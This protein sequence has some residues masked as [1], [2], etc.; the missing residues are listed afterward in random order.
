[1]NPLSRSAL[2]ERAEH[3]LSSVVVAIEFTLISVMIG[4]ILF[5]LMDHATP[6]L[7]DLKFEQMPYIVGGLVIILYLWTEVIAHSLSFIGW[8]IDLIHNLLYIVFAFVL[9][10][11]MHFLSDPL[12]WYGMS[13]VWALVSAVVVVYDLRLI[14]SRRGA[15]KGAKAALYQTALERQAGLVRSMPLAIGLSIVLLGLVAFFPELFLVRKGHIVL[16]IIQ[17]SAF[18]LFLRRTIRAFNRE[19]SQIAEKIVEDI[20]LEQ[21]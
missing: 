12:G 7:R 13:V 20:E 16:A 19:R 15:A 14:K 11:Q 4:V 21:E 6:I 5:P 3:N 2:R 8:P 18:L 1:M 9:A 17:L 10:V